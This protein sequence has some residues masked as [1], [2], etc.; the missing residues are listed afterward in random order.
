M[1][2]QTLGYIGLRTKNLEDWTAYASRF[3]GMQLVDKSRGTAS[4]RMD[5]K[6]Q[7]LVVH[8]DAGDA[9]RGWPCRRRPSSR[10]PRAGSRTRRP[11]P[12]RGAQGVREWSGAATGCGRSRRRRRRSRRARRACSPR[13]P[14]TPVR[15]RRP[16]RCRRRSP[17][18]S[19]PGGASAACRW[20]RRARTASCQ[21]S[22]RAGQPEDARPFGPG[23]PARKR[24]SQRS[25]PSWRRSAY[26]LLCMSCR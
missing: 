18:G 9:A 21:C 24:C 6:K 14:C 16:G 11:R 12:R 26:T 17:S 1:S 10:P 22:R 4:F 3:L 25:V 15:P 2:L 23:V 13:S 8:E 19:A 7:R 5:D 20:R